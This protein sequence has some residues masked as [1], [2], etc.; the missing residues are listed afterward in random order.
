MDDLWGQN[1]DEPLL[2]IH[3]LKVSKDMVTVYVKKNNTLKITLPNGIT[4]MK[5]DASDEECNKLQNENTGYYELN[6]VGT[7]NANTWMDN[8]TAQLFVVD[9]EIIDSNE[10]FF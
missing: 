2:C 3:G 7:A 5:F 8:T 1:M 9:Y 10:Y 4:L 6:V